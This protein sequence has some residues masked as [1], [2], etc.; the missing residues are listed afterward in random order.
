MLHLVPT[1]SLSSI[2]DIIF[3]ALILQ[4]FSSLRQVRIKKINLLGIPKYIPN[5]IRA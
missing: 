2:P 1:C 3:Q 4:K 5:T